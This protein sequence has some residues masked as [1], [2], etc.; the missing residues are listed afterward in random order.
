ML[1]KIH[2]TPITFRGEELTSV[3]VQ[4]VLGVPAYTMTVGGFVQ[5]GSMVIATNVGAGV[6]PK[7]SE[8]EVRQVSEILQVP[9]EPVTVNGGIPFLTSGVIANSKAVVVGSLTSGPELIMLSRVF[10]A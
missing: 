4:D 1:L 8:E 2:V 5:T 7:A 6:H 10:Q 3:E 9:A